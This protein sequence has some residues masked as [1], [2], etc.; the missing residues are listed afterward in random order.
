MKKTIKLAKL[1]QI[2]KSSLIQNRHTKSGNYVRIGRGSCY[3]GFNNYF[4]ETTIYLFDSW[5]RRLTGGSR[6]RD[7]ST[8]YYVTKEAW[9]GFLKRYDANGNVFADVKNG[10]T[11]AKAEVEVVKLTDKDRGTFLEQKNYAESFKGKVVTNG[12]SNGHFYGASVITNANGQALNKQ[13]Q[14]QAAQLISEQGFAFI[15]R[16]NDPN[17][18]DSYR[19]L[20]HK[21]AA[22]VK[23]GKLPI[24]INGYTAVKGTSVVTC[25]C[26]KLDNGYIKAA[27]KFLEEVKALK[28]HGNRT[29]KVYVG[30][31]EIT[32]QLVKDL[33]LK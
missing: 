6:G 32:E 2:L 30:A 9:A 14:A 27:G 12:K 23:I 22:P 4:S 8:T 1:K 29:L 3:D 16:F 31:A 25:G 19:V 28:N 10:V 21:V 17:G 18:Y 5:H 15:I 7:S 13:D 33:D 26:A 11:Q 24:K 20:A